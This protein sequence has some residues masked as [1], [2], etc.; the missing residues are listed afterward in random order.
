MK[1]QS[2]DSNHQED[3]YGKMN[4]NRKEK[5]GSRAIM[6]QEMPHWLSREER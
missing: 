4:D 6:G 5:I 3:D 1:V 2:G